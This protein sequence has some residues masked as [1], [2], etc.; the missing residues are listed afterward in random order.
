MNALTLER[1]R[2]VD[3]AIYSTANEMECEPADLLGYFHGSNISETARYLIES[4]ESDTVCRSESA[5]PFMFSLQ[6]STKDF[7]QCC[8]SPAL[9]N[10]IVKDDTSWNK[11]S[12]LTRPSRQRR[13]PPSK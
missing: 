10:R 1:A 13:V 2:I 5:L 7:Y 9:Y 3:L 11:P 4:E 8:P 6:Y 12:C